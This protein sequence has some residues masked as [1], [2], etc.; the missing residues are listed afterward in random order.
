M[1]NPL[2]YDTDMAVRVGIRAIRQLIREDTENK[3]MIY[4]KRRDS[5]EYTNTA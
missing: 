5:Y 1:D 3:H 2:I 4:I